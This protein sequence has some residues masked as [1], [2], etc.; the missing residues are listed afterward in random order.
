M[1]VMAG[2]T[3]F[4]VIAANAAYGKWVRPAIEA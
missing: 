4:T 2:I 3:F 1:M